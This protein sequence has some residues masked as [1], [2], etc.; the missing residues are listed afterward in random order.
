MYLFICIGGGGGGHVSKPHTY[1]QWKDV[2]SGDFVPWRPRPLFPLQRAACSSLRAERYFRTVD[3]SR[4]APCIVSHEFCDLFQFMLLKVQQLAQSGNMLPQLCWCQ[5][6]WIFCLALKCIFYAGN[7]SHVCRNTPPALQ[8]RMD[9]L[10]VH[11][12]CLCVGWRC[13][14]KTSFYQ[15]AGQG[16]FFLFSPGFLFSWVFRWASAPAVRSCY[17]CLCSVKF[18][19]GFK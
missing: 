8:R 13:P 15:W 2:A 4:N 7:Q 9:F 17:R 1:F 19:C 5:S 18:G 3:C 16:L 10:L 12:P 6:L 14:E 11:Q